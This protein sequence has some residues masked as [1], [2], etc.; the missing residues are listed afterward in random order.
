MSDPSSSASALLAALP[1]LE[2]SLGAL[3][4]QPWSETKEGLSTIDRAKMDVL[5]SYAINDLIWGEPS[6]SLEPTFPP[7]L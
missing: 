7:S 2:A 5:L 3:K 4:A 1:D 6:L